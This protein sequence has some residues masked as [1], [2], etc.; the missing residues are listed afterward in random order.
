MEVDQMAR[1]LAGSIL[2]MLALVVLVIGVVVIN[3]IIHKYWRNLGWF[4]T[5][6]TPSRYE[7]ISDEQYAKLVEQEKNKKDPQLIDPVSG[8]QLPEK[9]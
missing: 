8:E 4:N 7:I 2:L 9:K 5:W 6:F 3:N 1:I